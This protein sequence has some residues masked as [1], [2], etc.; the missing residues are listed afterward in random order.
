MKEPAIKEPEEISE[1]AKKKTAVEDALVVFSTIEKEDEADPGQVVANAAQS[2][3]D[4][5]SR[6]KA[7]NVVIYPY[8]HL[9]S[10][11]AS[12]NVA[13]SILRSMEE[14]LKKAGY[15]VTR[16]PFGFYKKFEISCK[17]HPLS[18]LSRSI[19]PTAPKE[20]A[21]LKTEYMVMDLDGKV[22]RP[23]EYRF[24]PAES[25]FKALVEKE[26]LKKGLVGGEPRYLEYCKKFGI[27]W[28]PFSDVGHMRYGPEGTLIFELISDYSWQVA[29]S[30]GL[31]VYKVRGTNMFDLSVPAVKEHADLFGGRLYELKLDQKN[32]VLRYAACHQQFAMVRDWTSSYRNL[33]FGTFE[34]ADS[35]RLEQSGELLL[36]FRVRKMHMPDLHIYCKDMD[37]A[38]KNSMKIHNVIYDEIRKIGRDYVSIY[39]TTRSFFEAEP[40][41]FA[42]LL[43]VEGKPILLNFVPDGI[44]YWVV[45]VEYTVI[46]EIGRPREIATFQIDVGN[47]KRFKITFTDEKGEK[48]YPPI[49]HTALLG[50]IERYLFAIL[51]A[52]ARVEVSGGKPMLPV[53]LSPVQVRIIPVTEAHLGRAEELS[54]ILESS[55]VRVDID[56]RDGTVEKRVRQA[57]V[58]WVPFVIVIGEREAKSDQFQVRIREKATT[59]NLSLEKLVKEIRSKAAGYPYRPLPLPKL[60]SSRPGY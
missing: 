42:R 1:S 15:N 45:N 59:A 55:N 7:S 19:L 44:Y 17:G 25:D 41:F 32:F 22:H 60:L 23:E 8:A 9:S 35:Y 4:V 40:E 34:V 14:T 53:W 26:A 48:R 52:G 3:A 18:E 27:G 20:K 29:N 33:P 24:K 43:K 36:C 54:K 50:T 5:A 49:I 12:R 47:A 30:L 39:N 38:M 2:I 11:L 37:E 51:D 31:P 6:V 21:V 16:S 58:D 10:S 13:L 28:E 57:E 46:D 56:D